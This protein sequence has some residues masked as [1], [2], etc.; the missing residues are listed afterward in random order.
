MP[1]PVLPEVGSKIVPR[2]FNKPLSSASKIR[3]FAAL[4]LIDPVGLTDSNFP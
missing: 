3:D 2:G 1:S 4:S